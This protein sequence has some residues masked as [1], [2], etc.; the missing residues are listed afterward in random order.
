[1]LLYLKC[2]RL[3]RL[4]K[5]DAII[6]RMGFNNVGADKVVN[7]LKSNKNIIIGGNIGKNKKTHMNEAN[8]DYLICFEKLFPYVNYFAINVSS[9]NTE[10]LRELQ[11]KES[12]KILLQ[13]I[14]KKNHI[15][16]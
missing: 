1:M 10:N 9:P 12:L 7:R 6:N 3:F 4:T 16:I 8:Q 15:L 11:H 5:D 13:S 14:Q 2:Q